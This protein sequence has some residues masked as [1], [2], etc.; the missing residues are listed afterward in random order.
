MTKELNIDSNQADLNTLITTFEG[1]LGELQ[2]TLDAMK[3]FQLTFNVSLADAP[4]AE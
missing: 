2:T 1:Q 4:V 3:A